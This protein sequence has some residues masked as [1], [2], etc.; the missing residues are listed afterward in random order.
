M[1]LKRTLTALATLPLLGLAALASADDM[2]SYTG[3]NGPANWGSSAPVCA[4]GALQSPIVI[5]GTE[6]ALLNRIETNYSVAPVDMHNDRHSIHFTYTPGSMLKIGDKQFELEEFHFHTPAE[7]RILDTSFPM[8][9]HFKHKM[10]DGTFAVLA[11]MVKEGRSNLAAEEIWP[12]LPLEPDQT[13][14]R[15]DIKINARD[16]MPDNKAVFRY[17]GSLTTP[18]CTEGINWYIFQQPIEFSSQQIAAIHG[19]MGDNARAL[20]PRNNRMI[21][22]ALPN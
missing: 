9:I 10:A 21:L 15:P 19:I 13:T 4:N 7:H 16:F 17:M 2:W 14:R 22:N 8:E 6:P 20:Q 11:V 12:H 3:E 1:T 5:E 18:P